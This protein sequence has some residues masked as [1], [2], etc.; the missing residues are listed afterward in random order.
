MGGVAL[1]VDAQAGEHEPWLRR[2]STPRCSATIPHH[3]P[4]MHLRWQ[5]SRRWIIVAFPGTE[6]RAMLA[7]GIVVHRRVR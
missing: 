5:G 2:H 6:F 3:L 1:G 4:V 7:E